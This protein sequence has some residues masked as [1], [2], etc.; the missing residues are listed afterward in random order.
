MLPIVGFGYPQAEKV[1]DGWGWIKRGSAVSKEG[2]MVV[3]PKG[4]EHKPSCAEEYKILLIEPVET[5]NTGDAGGDF[6]DTDL[7]WI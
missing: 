1:S 4:V 6:T 2:E 3:M 7:E 5:I